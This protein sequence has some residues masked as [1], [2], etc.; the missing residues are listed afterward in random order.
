MGKIK[1]ALLRRKQ[2]KLIINFIKNKTAFYEV[3]QVENKKV[4]R[5]YLNTEVIE[6]DLSKA[7][8][9]LFTNNK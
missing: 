1:Q 3:Y 6:G 7:I 2:E 8:I 9:D 4:Y 5:L